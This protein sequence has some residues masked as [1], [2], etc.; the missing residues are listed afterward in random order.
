MGSVGDGRGDLRSY[1][2]RSR[3]TSLMFTRS[4][5]GR[6]GAQSDAKGLIN[7]S[8]QENLEP[9]NHQL[10]VSLARNSGDSL[11]GHLLQESLCPSSQPPLLQGAL[12]EVPVSKILRRRAHHP[13]V[14][15]HDSPAE[16]QHRKQCPAHSRSAIKEG[17]WTQVKRR[18]W[19]RKWEAGC[20]GFCFT[21][22]T[23]ECVRKALEAQEGSTHSTWRIAWRREQRWQTND[24]VWLLEK[25]HVGE[26]VVHG[27]PS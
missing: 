13:T 20:Q 27:C 23:L 22:G 24:G 12:L 21:L 19:R 4:C 2:Q 8:H 16:A 1:S 17:E 5:G 11:P 3:G 26:V 15:D 25:V 6:S 9:R 10:T 14:S 7:C 18:G